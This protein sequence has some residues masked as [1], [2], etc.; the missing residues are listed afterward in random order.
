MLSR[1]GLKSEV[2]DLKLA[3]APLALMALSIAACVQHS[4]PGTDTVVPA[5]GKSAMV[6]PGSPGAD[7][8]VLLAL[9]EACWGHQGL[10]GWL[11][12][13]P[14][15]EWEGVT[16]NEEGR[17]VELDLRH[18]GL[19]GELPLQIG[20]LDRLER[21]FLQENQFSGQIPRNWVI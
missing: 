19:G 3:V 17:V 11:S 10:Y 20:E 2:K 5:P 14:L 6:Q 1:P 8:D 9:Y 18:S 12:D 15:D 4:S 21:L 16:T 13:A 7:R